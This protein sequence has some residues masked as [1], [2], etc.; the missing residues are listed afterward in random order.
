VGRMRKLTAEERRAAKV[1]LYDDLDAGR[2]TIA[3]AVRRM[4]RVTGMT[5][6]EFA[7]R[8]AGLSTSALAKIER[9][10]ANPTVAT[11]DEI[12]RA[13]GL[14]VAFRR[15]PEGDLPPPRRE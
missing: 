9:G 8:V 14:E 10:Q 11:L 5:Q 4:R 1:A 15:R 12:G 6:R 2:L 13:F 3:E 7:E